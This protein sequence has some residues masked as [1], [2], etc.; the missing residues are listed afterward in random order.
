M[1]AR[2]E[3][4]EAFWRRR[5]VPLEVLVEN[6]RALEREGSLAAA[7]MTWRQALRLFPGDAQALLGLAGLSE[8]LGNLDAAAGA[9]KL[10]A[11][12]SLL[13]EHFF[14]LAE[15][16]HARGRNETAANIW[17]AIAGADP[18]DHRDYLD[19]G[20]AMEK[21]G[22]M[23]EARA[24]L[25][26]AA[27]IEPKDAQAF[28]HLG[29]IDTA[30]GRSRDGLRNLARA[31]EIDPKHGL[32]TAWVAR[33]FLMQDRLEE[34][35]QVA[36]RATETAPDET[37]AWAAL[38]RVQLAR[39]AA[40]EAASAFYRALSLDPRSIEAHAGLAEQR[41]SQGRAEE[42]HAGFTMAAALSATGAPPAV[43]LDSILSVGGDQEVLSGYMHP[44]SGTSVSVVVVA[45][46]RIGNLDRCLDG[47]A[48]QT[49]RPDSIEIVIA[50]ITPEQANAPVARRYYE[51]LPHVLYLKADG[52]TWLDGW[53]AASG[54]ASGSVVVHLADS[55]RPLPDLLESLLRPFAEPDRHLVAGRVL[56]GFEETPGNWIGGMMSPVG[57]G[58][59]LGHFD[60]LDAGDEDLAFRPAEALPDCLAISRILLDR[61]RAPHPGPAPLDRL[62][63][64]G[65]GLKALLDE[66]EAAG[67][68]CHYAAGA[69]AMRR[70]DAKRISMTGLYR[71]AFAEGV[72][73]SFEDARAGED[74]TPAVQAPV[75][76]PMEWSG[77]PD[78]P[79]DELLTEG[80][81][82]GYAW[83]RREMARDPAL[84]RFVLKGSF[85]DS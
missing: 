38:G 4:S 41:L 52:A 6:A 26:V 32:A 22:N 73:T 24:A 56:P 16:E 44:P 10:V 2:N 36:H 14:R 45:G 72:K 37:G 54:R 75:S 55:V 25:V 83:H 21:L 23:A 66:A 65:P 34:A 74:R 1:T 31:L 69:I 7:A 50:D 29:R 67:E 49:L 8:R 18:S 61:A 58:W 40:R 47:L 17:R 71:A 12:R 43:A 79:I 57:R 78:L 62:Q 33:A 76:P 81:D 9:V 80:R 63:Y 46:G 20:L 3:Q 27:K 84:R 68:S 5:D 11:E 42:A 53:K 64:A 51:K 48:R 85:R 82:K 13:P 59:R 30:A 15:I 39:L 35:L 77:P 70:I 19:R 60:C 28:Y